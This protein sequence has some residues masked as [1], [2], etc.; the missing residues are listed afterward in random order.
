M[1]TQHGYGP[2][3]LAIE[4]GKDQ[5]LDWVIDEKVNNQ[6]DFPGL[7]IDAY[8][9]TKLLHHSVNNPNTSSATLTKLLNY[10]WNKNKDVVLSC[11]LDIFNRAL[12]RK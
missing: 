2:L 1:K 5:V 6:K 8:D 3:E 10:S 4:A 9:P 12:L 11:I 7:E